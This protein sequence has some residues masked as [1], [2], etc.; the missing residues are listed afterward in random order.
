MCVTS[1]AVGCFYLVLGKENKEWTPY[2]FS[3]GF[4]KLKM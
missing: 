2:I 1:R 3:K 4:L